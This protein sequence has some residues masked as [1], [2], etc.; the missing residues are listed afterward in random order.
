MSVSTES[1]ALQDLAKRL[2]T[3]ANEI[4]LDVLDRSE[5]T[6]SYFSG[7]TTSSTNLSPSDLPTESLALGIGRYTILLGLLPEVPTP[8]SVL[9]TLRR[10][11]NQCV[12]AR[13]FL[14][15]HQ[16]LDLQL[17]LVGPRGSE[18][19]EDWKALALMIERDDRV[20]R[21][22][23]WLRPENPGHD[24]ESFVEFIK[25]TFLARPWNKAGKFGDVALDQLSDSG[26][27]GDELP[28]ST[29]DEW[30]RIALD[31]DKTPDE[32]VA[33]LVNAWKIRGN[34]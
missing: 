12:V 33:S 3:S 1:S 7:G 28:C 22:L 34:S 29:T 30:E 21:K 10:Y 14:S 20:A 5:L 4:A 17:I 23:A 15:A 11:R 27:I 19:Q 16:S 13:S 26:A 31:T 8:E 18:C 9:E 2:R 32:I 24:A 6:G 25:R